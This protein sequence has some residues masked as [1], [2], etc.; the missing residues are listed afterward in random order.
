[1][2]KTNGQSVSKQWKRR[3]LLKNVSS[4]EFPDAGKMDQLGLVILTVCDISSNDPR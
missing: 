2:M 3:S 4:V 1:M